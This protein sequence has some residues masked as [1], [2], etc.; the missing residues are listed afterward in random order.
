[1]GQQWGQRVWVRKGGPV[2]CR[3]WNDLRAEEDGYPSRNVQSV[4]ICENL[5]A[6]L[7][8]LTLMYWIIYALSA[9]MYY[10][11]SYTQ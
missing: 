4:E 11:C 7:L 5:F 1:M 3:R 6:L 8:C 2:M 10:N 9:S